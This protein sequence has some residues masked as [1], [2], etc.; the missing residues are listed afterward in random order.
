[1]HGKR[2]RRYAPK[3]IALTVVVIAGFTGAVMLAYAGSAFFNTRMS[4]RYNLEQ[5]R[6]G[7]GMYKLT[8]GVNPPTLADV[9]E[10]ER[11]LKIKPYCPSTR[12]IYE[13]DPETGRVRCPYRWHSD[14]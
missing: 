12:L 11:D 14:L 4:C 8:Y 1:M 5:V 7:I 9:R 6:L 10:S 2:D 3:Q 13:Y